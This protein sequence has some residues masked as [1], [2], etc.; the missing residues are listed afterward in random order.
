MFNIILPSLTTENNF[1]LDYT[2]GY[3]DKELSFRCVTSN[4]SI[5]LFGRK[6]G[7]ILLLTIEIR[8]FLTSVRPF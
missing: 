3:S 8:M 2:H 7:K 4:E 6:K 1:E 5:S